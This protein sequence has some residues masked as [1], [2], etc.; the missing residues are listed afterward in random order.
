MDHTQPKL[1]V[2]LGSVQ[3]RPGYS[4]ATLFTAALRI[5]EDTGGTGGGRCGECLNR[6]GGRLLP[7]WENIR[8]M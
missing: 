8:R 4:P 1:M 3:W 7:H 5:R 2:K 6:D